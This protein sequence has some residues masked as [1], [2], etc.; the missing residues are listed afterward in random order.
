[1]QLS[2]AVIQTISR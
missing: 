2:I 1:M